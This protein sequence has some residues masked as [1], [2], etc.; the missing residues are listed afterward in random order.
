M[1][2]GLA[3]V[4]LGHDFPRTPRRCAHPLPAFCVFKRSSDQFTLRAVGMASN[5]K[6]HEKVAPRAC[7]PKNVGINQNRQK[8]IKLYQTKVYLHHLL[9]REVP[10]PPGGVPP[11]ARSRGPVYPQAL[12]CFNS[13][14]ARHFKKRRRGG[15]VNHSSSNPPPP[16]TAPSP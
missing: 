13:C 2:L 16:Q 12:S 15:F 10:Q 14:F 9:A 6:G 1:R 5:V 8:F 4:G 11:P 3:R 7:A